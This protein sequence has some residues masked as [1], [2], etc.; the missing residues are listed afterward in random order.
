LTLLNDHQLLDV[1]LISPQ[2][3][4]RAA[5]NAQAVGGTI[6]TYDLGEAKAPADAVLRGYFQARGLSGEPLD[7]AIQA[8]SREALGHAQRA[9]QNASALSR[10][11]TAF[12]A[13]KLRSI[14]LSSQQQWSE[15]AAKHAAALE[16]ELR[17]LHDQMA[18][19]S[20]DPQELPSMNDADTAIDDPPAFARATNRL[21][22]R[23][24]SLNRNVGSEFASGQQPDAPPTDIDSLVAATSNAIPLQEA[25]EITGFA[26]QLNAA[27]RTAQ[28]SRQHSRPEM[29]PPNRP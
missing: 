21:L 15:M 3:V 27:A 8:F 14:S 17:G 29:Q 5:K 16:V 7:A 13:T 20:S 25:V 2:D 28:M 1:R 26:V 19:L 18:R 10:L 4:I 12:P 9:L 23:T 6:S 11:G 24:Q 22:L